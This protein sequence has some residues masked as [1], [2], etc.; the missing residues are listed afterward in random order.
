MRLKHPIFALMNWYLLFK[1][2]HFMAWVSWFAGLFYL[3]RLFVY[4]AEAFDKPPGERET[5]H[6]QFSQM[7][8]LLYRVIMTPA[9]TLTW[10]MGLSMVYCMGW[11]WWKAS[12]WLHWKLLLV[13]LLSGYH[14]WCGRIAGRLAAGERVMSSLRFRL[15]NEIATLFLVAIVLLAVFKNAL[16]FIYAFIALLGLGLVLG[17]AVRAYKRSRDRAENKA[18]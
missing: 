10:V 18:D 13:L 5:L 17:L 2:L 15:F 9:M 11:D 12:I 4:H 3:P 1:A 7:E 16:D 14:H 8:R 6:R